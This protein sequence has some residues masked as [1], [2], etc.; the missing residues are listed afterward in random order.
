MEHWCEL[1]IMETENA[2]IMFFVN[3][4]IGWGPI[5]IE[6]YLTCIDPQNEEAFWFT[7]VHHLV[8]PTRKEHQKFNELVK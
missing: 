8:N 2:E 4:L 6:H 7:Q 5:N 1:M 3:S